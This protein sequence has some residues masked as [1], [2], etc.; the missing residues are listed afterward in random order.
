MVTHDEGECTA[1]P[2]HLM[3]CVAG[4]RA[5]HRLVMS[6]LWVG[7]GLVTGPNQTHMG[8]GLVITMV[9]QTCMVICIQY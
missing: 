8:L 7:Y 6:W 4:T 5:P 2:R 9:N 3:L 1:T